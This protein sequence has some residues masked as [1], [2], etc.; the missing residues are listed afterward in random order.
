[1]KGAHLQRCRSTV[2]SSDSA[3]T[4][5]KVPMMCKPSPGTQKESGIISV[6]P[7]LQGEG[8]PEFTR[9]SDI[10]QI[11]SLQGLNVRVCKPQS[12]GLQGLPQRWW[13]GS[14][15]CTSRVP[16]TCATPRCRRPPAKRGRSTGRSGRWWC[17]SSLTDP[18][19]SFQCCPRYCALMPF[20]AIKPV[21]VGQAL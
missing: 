8:N 3:C 6:K 17:L 1:M 4:Y 9:K 13:S 14:T 19:P 5:R 12:S 2:H 10:V 11:T 20:R 15:W 18:A 21:S 7:S 16:Q